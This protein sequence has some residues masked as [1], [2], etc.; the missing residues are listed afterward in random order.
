[1]VPTAT[2]SSAKRDPSIRFVKH[3]TEHTFADPIA[4]RNIK[5]EVYK[6]KLRRSPFGEDKFC[7]N[8]SLSFFLFKKEQEMGKDSFSH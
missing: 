5:T 7:L 3:E 2:M 6:V 8:F 4:K 1:M